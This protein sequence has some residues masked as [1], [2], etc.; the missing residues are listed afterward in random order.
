MKTTWPL[1]V[2]IVLCGCSHAPE[3]TPSYRNLNADYVGIEVCG[4]CHVDKY[5]TF[6]EAQMGRSWEAAVPAN[7]VANFDDPD[8]VYDPHNDMHYQAF[9]RGGD[10]FIQEF[11]LEGADTTHVRIEQVSYIVGSGQ[12]TN[13]HIMD[14]GGYLYQMPLTWYAQDGKWDLPPG[15][16]DGN[17]RRFD[18]PIPLKCMTCH[19]G[20]P[21]FVDGSENRYDYV[22]HGIDCERCHGPGSVHVEAMRSGGAVNVAEEIDWTIVNPGKLPVNRQF[23]ICQGCHM[24]GATVPKQGITFADF[25]PSMRLDD[26]ENVFWPRYADSI[27]QFVM[28]SH[29]DRL[30]LSSCFKESYTAEQLTCVTCHDPHVSIETLGAD[31]YRTVCLGCH[32]ESP[33]ELR[34]TEEEAARA[35]VSD[36]CVSCHMPTSGSEDIPHVRI[37]DHFIRSPVAKTPAILSADEAVKNKEFIRLASLIERAPAA[38]DVARGYMTYYEEVT[39]HPGFLDSAAVYLDRARDE[40]PLHQVA[41]PLVRMYFLK[42]DYRSIVRLAR[43]GLSATDA[44]TAYRIGEAFLTEGSPAEA[45]PHM[46]KAVSRAPGNLRFRSRLA[47]AF[48]HENRPTE[49]AALLDEVLDNNPKFTEAFNNR[50]FAR[51]LLGDIEAAEADFLA[52]IALD[53]DLEGALGNLASLY[54]NT[55]RIAEAR[56]YARRLL[57]RDPQNPQYQQLWDLVK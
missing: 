5:Q 16:K 8:P 14:V 56:P 51:L 45:R 21:K 10:L 7:S 13:S 15:F 23:D 53:P 36:Y 50:G 48:L 38:I 17:N 54:Y 39:N 42:E 22:P 18:R 40:T 44:W 30:Q 43:A 27:Q 20:M 4:S 6:T 2:A 12:H 28:A 55:G 41:A 35:A 37:T 31:H 3:A 52:A 46:E 34:C 26:I 11:R 57:K 33:D 29:P 49:A 32:L 47:V 1:L 9:R 19:N 25:R 24:Q